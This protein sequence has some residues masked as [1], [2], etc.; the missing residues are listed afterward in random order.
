MDEETQ[1]TDET[2]EVQENGETSENAPQ[3]EELVKA[4]ELANNYK[5]RAEK[6]EAERKALEAELSKASKSKDSTLNVEDYIDISTSLEGLDAREK[7]R[8]AREHKLTG[9]SLKEIRED[10]DFKLWQS[11]YQ[12]KME[13]ERLSLKPT[14]TQ[15]ESDIPRSFKETLASASIAEKE[16]L[17]T[18]AGLYRS[19]RPRA[20][21]VNLGRGK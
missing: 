9:R 19:P 4:S 3:N 14:G 20:D 1:V 12:A 15:S 11:A 5:I 21:R 2:L 17:L 6:A 8:L 10:E 7:E 13:K 18:E 16:R